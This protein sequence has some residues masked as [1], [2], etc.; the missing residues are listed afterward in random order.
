[1]R[2]RRNL[3]A[4]PLLLDQLLDIFPIG[5]V[6]LLG[7][8]WTSQVFNQALGECQ[9]LSRGLLFQFNVR[10]VRGA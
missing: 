10:F 5:V 4:F 3:L 2:R 9:L 6:Q 7:L 8:E 1:M